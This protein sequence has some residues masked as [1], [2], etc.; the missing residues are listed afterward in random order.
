[1]SLVSSS[2]AKKPERDSNI[3]LLRIVLMVMVI[4]H[5]LI[6]KCDPDSWNKT[7]L[8]TLVNTFAIIAVNCF[9][10][11]SG[12]YGIKFKLKSLVSFIFQG[13]FYSVGAYII[14]NLLLSPENFSL[15][16]LVKR[17]LPLTY[18]LWWFLNAFVG[19]YILSPFINK[20]IE[21]L[22]AYQAGALILILLYLS[23]SYPITGNNFYGGG[24]YGLF[25]ML[26]IYIIARYCGKYIPYIKRAIPIHI[27]IYL[28]TFTLVMGGVLLGKEDFAWRLMSYNSPLVILGAVF[29]FYCFKKLK[30]K[31]RIINK[32]APLTFGVYLIHETPDNRFILKNIIQQ[33]NNAIDNP[34]LMFIALIAVA[35][36]VFLICAGIEKIRQLICDPII[37]FMDK[38]TFGLQSKL[39]TSLNKVTTR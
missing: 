20:G 10:F 25:T 4:L 3:E 39:K 14:Y 32:I 13:I 7:L 18:P 23:C 16:D 29:F 5:H 30:L 24:G 11:I 2:K 19:V 1:M 26:L 31:S 9:I 8:F 15:V 37:D 21:A 12:Y 27:C 6:I 17:F 33:V 28:L 34:I 38:K 35:I 22:K 36:I